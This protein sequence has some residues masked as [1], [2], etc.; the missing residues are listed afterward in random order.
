MKELTRIITIQLTDVVKNEQQIEYYLK[1]GRKEHDERLWK[2]SF[3]DTYD[4]INVGIQYFLLDKQFP[5][6][7]EP[8]WIV[9]ACGGVKKLN[10]WDTPLDHELMAA[11]NCF[12]TEEEAEKVASKVRQLLK[13]DAA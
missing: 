9:N 1:D 4:D 13:G 11:G 12:Q 5:C 2:E 6:K 3:L 10:W 8:F 7:G